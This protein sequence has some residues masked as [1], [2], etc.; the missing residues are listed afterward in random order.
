MAP[1]NC[2]IAGLSDP[3]AAGKSSLKVEKLAKEYTQCRPRV[4][5]I[6]MKVCVV[7]VAIK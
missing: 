6:W 5:T 1:N 3:C 7:V 4:H 2:M